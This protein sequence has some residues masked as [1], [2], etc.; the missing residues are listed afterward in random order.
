MDQSRNDDARKRHWR[1]KMANRVLRLADKAA[2]KN[3]TFLYLSGEADHDRRV[4]LQKKVPERR[5]LIVEQDKQVADRLRKS[6]KTVANCKLDQALLAHSDP[7][8]VVWADLCCTLC[9]SP[10]A[11]VFNALT[12]SSGVVENT[13]V[14]LNV[15]R[16]RDAG[17]PELGRALVDAGW[18]PPHFMQNRAAIL[19]CEKLRQCAVFGVEGGA[20]E[21]ALLRFFS[22]AMKS[23]GAYATTYKNRVNAATISMDSVCFLAGPIIGGAKHAP[24]KLRSAGVLRG[25]SAHRLVAAKAIQ[26]MRANGTI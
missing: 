3:R 13:V 11:T 4:F 20:D 19:L 24:A 8:S 18:L 5:L 1:R 25:S 10:A 23:M 9:G 15:M 6:G 14:M 7:L 26:T 22:E 2:L 12:M 16:G 21:K 17:A